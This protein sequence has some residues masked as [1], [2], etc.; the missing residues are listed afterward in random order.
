MAKLADW[1][2]AE[3]CFDRDMVFLFGLAFS[4]TES[5]RAWMQRTIAFEDIF[6]HILIFKKR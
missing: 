2:A 3:F 1:E 6:N 5:K 4:E